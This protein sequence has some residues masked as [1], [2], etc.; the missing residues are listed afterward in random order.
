V[1]PRGDTTMTGPS[2]D[3]AAPG[4]PPERYPQEVH[5]AR[6]A[7][8]LAHPLRMRILAALDHGEASPSEVAEA[9]DVSLPKLSYHFQVLRDMGLIEL[10]RT[11]RV[12]GAVQHHYR[13]ATREIISARAWEG[14][15]IAV[16]RSTAGGVLQQIIED[17]AGAVGAGGFDRGEAHAIRAVFELDDQGW[18]ELSEALTAVVARAAE[19]EADAARR[20]SADERSVAE[21]GTLLFEL[22][23]LD[24][25]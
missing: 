14:L 25:R 2:S 24:E 13:T 23:R 22:G 9:L 19:I 1:R 11:T 8:A 10:A 20:S 3:A 17:I 12:R 16:R 18:A 7:R 21:L 15:P 6:R 5:D 4:G